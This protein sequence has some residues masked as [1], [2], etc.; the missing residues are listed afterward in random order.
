[1][2]G[3][4]WGVH[5][6]LNARIMKGHLRG[7]CCPVNQAQLILITPS[8][9]ARFYFPPSLNI[10]HRLHSPTQHPPAQRSQAPTMYT[11]RVS[12]QALYGP[13]VVRTAA[14]QAACQPPSIQQWRGFQED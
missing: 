13:P 2:P 5:G 14:I 9:K 12:T 11:Y 3:V 6:W 7:G 1:M 8:E 4:L 10:P